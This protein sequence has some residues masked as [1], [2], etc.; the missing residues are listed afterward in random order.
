MR[1]RHTLCLKDAHLH[2]V[3]ILE[4]HLQ[5]VADWVMDQVDP[6]ELKLAAEEFDRLGYDVP[7]ALGA[8]TVLQRLQQKEL[9]T[10]DGVTRRWCRVVEGDDLD[11]EDPEYAVDRHR[12]RVLR[13]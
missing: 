9:V 13:D 4:K 8:Q 12:P 6:F 10:Y 7:G 5:L 11:S 2:G 3:L 1:K